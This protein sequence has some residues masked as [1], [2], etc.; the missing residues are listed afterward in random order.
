VHEH[1]F[2]FVLVER[3]EFAVLLLAQLPKLVSG[4]HVV[5]GL[6][7]AVL[8]VDLGRQ[9]DARVV[10]YLHARVIRVLA[11]ALALVWAALLVLLVIDILVDTWVDVHVH[12]TRVIVAAFGH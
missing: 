3:S 5:S 1:P 4:Q 2:E 12:E 6:Q 10:R 11:L 9:F 7:V 8:L